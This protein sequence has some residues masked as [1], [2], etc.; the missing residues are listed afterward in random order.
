M[1]R[2]DDDEDTEDTTAEEATERKASRRSKREDDDDED[3]E[4]ADDVKALKA[5]ASKVIQRGWGSAEKVKSADSPYAQNLKLTEA[6]QLV[7]FL[8]DDPY[9]SYRQHWINERQGQKSFVCISD[10]HPEGCPLCDAGS[11]PS[12]RFA[13][14]V[15]LMNPGEDPILRSYEFGSRVIDQLKTFHQNP[16]TGPLTKHYWAISRTGK[17]ASTQVSH[18]VVKERDLEEEWETAPITEEDLKGLRKNAYTSDILFI[19]TRK[20]LL[21]IAA[22]ELGDD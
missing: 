19:P 14:N 2:Y 8:E 20:S 7:K 6:E 15:A 3:D 12:S 5:Q 10:L 17:K 4:L 13:F 18:Q 16:K 11:R 1:G 9:V 21:E 22:E